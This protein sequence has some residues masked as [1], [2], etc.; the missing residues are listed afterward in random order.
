MKSK[1][2]PWGIGNADFVLHE[3]KEKEKVRQKEKE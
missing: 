1:Y 2:L 3:K